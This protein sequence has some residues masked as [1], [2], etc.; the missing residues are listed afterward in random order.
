MQVYPNSRKAL[1]F[2]KPSN[3][4]E[5]KDNHNEITVVLKIFLVLIFLGASVLLRYRI[6]LLSMDKFYFSVFYPIAC[7]M[8]KPS[9]S[10]FFSTFSRQ[11]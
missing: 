6:E 11:K 4:I 9:F 5:Y 3:K 7:T 8:V 10:R 1:T 2:Q